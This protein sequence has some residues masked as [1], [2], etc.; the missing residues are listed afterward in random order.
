MPLYEYECEKCKHRFETPQH[1][2]YSQAKTDCP[3]CGGLAKRVPSSFSFTF[4]H[5]NT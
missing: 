3:K 1:F 2:D 5:P 4:A